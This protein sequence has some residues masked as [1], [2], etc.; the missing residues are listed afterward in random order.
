MRKKNR[1]LLFICALVPG[2]G[3]MYLGYMKRGLSLA[4]IF[5]FS[6]FLAYLIGMDAML[7]L[8]PLIFLYSFFD[9]FNIRAQLENGIAEP[10][11]YIFGLPSV[12]SER[13]GILLNRRH[14]II[15]W[16]LLLL[17]LYML[18][19]T[20]IRNVLQHLAEYS[21][22]FGLLYDILRW[23]IPRLFVTFLIIFLGIWFIRGPKSSKK[24]TKSGKYSDK[25]TDDIP[26]FTPPPVT[27]EIQPAPESKSESKQEI[28]SE[29]KPESKPE[30]AIKRPV[31]QSEFFKEA[32][33][34][35]LPPD[36]FGLYADIM[37]NIENIEKLKNSE[38][39]DNPENTEESS[40]ET[41]EKS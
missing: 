33:H 21:P 9:A 31:Y 14:S 29:T 36:P 32:P 27:E 10:D 28:K 24:N 18:Y 26:C 5:W 8:M 3:Q 20:L 1:L 30:A 4:S 35:P 11:T 6:I 13:L 12:D 40:D 34:A 7:F 16:G 2:C 41:D 25:Y 15:G 39:P 38:N 19:D 22:R 23:D 37:E 17:G